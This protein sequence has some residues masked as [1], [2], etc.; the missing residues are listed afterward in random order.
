M[1]SF[2]T[3]P[4]P[5]NLEQTLNDPFDI[6]QRTATL[7]LRALFFQPCLYSLFPVYRTGSSSNRT[8]GLA[9]S[10]HFERDLLRA[11]LKPVIVEVFILCVDFRRNI[12]HSHYIFTAWT[13][14]WT[15]SV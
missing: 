14:E 9:R 6:V 8:T 4:K 3:E 13:G 7:I 15:V 5:F 10:V 12:R 1:Y 11:P 2:L